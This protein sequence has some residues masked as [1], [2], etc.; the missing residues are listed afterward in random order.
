MAKEFA[1]KQLVNG[2][3]FSFEN[4]ADKFAFLEVKA[5]LTSQGFTFAGSQANEA[6]FI[7]SAWR[8]HDNVLFALADANI[9]RN[10]PRGPFIPDPFNAPVNEGPTWV[11]AYIKPVYEDD[12]ELGEQPL[13][14]E[15]QM[16][17]DVVLPSLRQAVDYCNM[18]LELTGG[19]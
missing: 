2:I 17:L 10:G 18:I 13:H 14:E 8:K 15:C 4:A 6:L 12:W 1:Y 19:N 3:T 11:S 9:V 7:A 16:V 5:Y